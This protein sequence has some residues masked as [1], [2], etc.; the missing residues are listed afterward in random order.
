[1]SQLSPTQALWRGRIEAG[2]RVAA[3]ALDLLLAFGDKASHLIAP[4]DSTQDVEPG[5]AAGK[6]KRTAL[7]DVSR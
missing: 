5:D 2:L 7:S 1:M 6:H 3:P 4:E